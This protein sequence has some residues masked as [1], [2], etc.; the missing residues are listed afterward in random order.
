MKF[1]QV[2]GALAALGLACGGAA[3]RDV[4][5]TLGTNAKH[6][7]V[8]NGWDPYVKAV[9]QDLNGALRFKLF[10]GGSLVSHR[11][12]MNGV[13]DGVAE[14]G[15]MVLTYYPAE[16]PHANFIGDL[17]LIGEDVGVMAGAAS[18]FYLLSCAECLGEF[19]RQNVIFLGTYATSPFMLISKPKI[20]TL[21]EL[22]GRKIRVAGANW[23]RWAQHFGGT[24]VALAANEMF[25]AMGQNVIDAAIQAPSALV[26][27][28]LMDVAK[29][30]TMLPLGTAHATSPNGFNKAFW[31]SLASR[32]R[33]SLIERSAIMVAGPSFGYVQQDA[34]ALEAAPGKGIAIQQPSPELLATSKAFA[35]R[36]VALVI[37]EYRAKHGI[38]DAAEKAARFQSLVEK[39]EGLAKGAKGDQA[40]LEALYRREI[41]QKISPETFG[42]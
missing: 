26:S 24:G 4:K 8:A 12:A 30:V 3:A 11:A 41:F 39:W 13:R 19:E 7:V 34:A 22:R 37:G 6:P 32:E 33:K 25:E 5:V 38:A 16:F 9:E 1:G 31:R 15:L 2:I 14:A 10:L 27:Y 21:D 23:N 20:T 17:A 36:D 18:E 35:D 40:A 29:H 28:S 42:M